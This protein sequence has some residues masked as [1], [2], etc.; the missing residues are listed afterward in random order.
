[1]RS[2]TLILQGN[3]LDDEELIETL[4]S[5]KV[6]SQR[7]EERVAEQTKTQTIINDTRSSYRPVA[8]RVSQLFFVVAD[9][10]S[11]DPMY[12]YSLEWFNGVF[13]KAIAVRLDLT[14]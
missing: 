5:S 8:H 13:L 11:V 6:A 7:I 1:M 14:W 3:I 9:L 4:S 12:Q 10:G 2:L